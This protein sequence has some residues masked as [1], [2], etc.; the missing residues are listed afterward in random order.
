ME[1]KNIKHILW[2]IC[3]LISFVACKDDA[4]DGKDNENDGIPPVATNTWLI[5][6]L[7]DI[8]TY[9]SSAPANRQSIRLLKNEN[10]NIQ[11]VIQTGNNETLNIE[12]S[13]DPN[14][15]FNCRRIVAFEKM[16]DVLVPCDGKV[17]PQNKSVKV[18]LSFKASR[19]APAGRYKEII[20]FKNSSEEYAVAIDITIENAALP[21]TPTLASVFG[22]NPENFILSG[23][24]EDQKIEKRKEVSDLLLTYRISPYF[25]T[26]LSGS[27]KT[28]VFSSPYKWDDDR[29]WEYLKD[30]RFSRI[31]LPCHNLNDEEL[32]TM[33]NKAKA[34]GLLD[35]AYFYVWDEPTQMAEYA[36]IRTISDRIHQY[37][38]EAKVI[39]TFYCG[40]VDGE[41]KDDLFAVFDIL[42]GATNIFCTGVWSLQ[43]SESRSQM[44]RAKLKSGQ[45]RWNYVCM[46]DQ[47]G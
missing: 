8:E 47:P 1:S 42:N 35:K 15:E 11:L 22:I 41:H 23:L 16:N 39:T 37:A 33:L 9:T 26:W 27:M 29:S 44:C 19:T 5:N 45:E 17:K 30:E 6:S 40:P 38:P 46:A 21:E 43:G 7:A 20:R 28:E 24:S 18:W 34:N 25:S 14:I 3:L 10:E 36:Q 12:R 2:C 4:V 32:R 13:G 31:A